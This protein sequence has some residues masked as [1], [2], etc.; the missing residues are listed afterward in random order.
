MTSVFSVAI[1]VVGPAA[2]AVAR[3]DRACAIGYLILGGD[4]VLI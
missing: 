2:V 4:G 1:L 3:V